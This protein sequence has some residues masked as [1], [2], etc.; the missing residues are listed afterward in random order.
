MMCRDLVLKAPTFLF[1][2]FQACRKMPRG[3]WLILLNSMVPVEGSKEAS[4]KSQEISRTT[5]QTQPMEQKVR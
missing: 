5:D 4:G 1:Y 2:I 3:N